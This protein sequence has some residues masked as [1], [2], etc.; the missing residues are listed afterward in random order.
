MPLYWIVMLLMTLCIGYLG[1][2]NRRSELLM[3]N[4][5]SSATAH[6]MLVY[7]NA[8]AIYAHDNPG[9]T[10]SPA[11]TQLGLPGWYVH[12]VGINGYVAGGKSY[13]FFPSPPNG[14]V[15]ALIN[16]TGS[17][18]IGYA[19]GSQ[20]VSPY[21]GQTGISLPGTVPNGSAVAFQ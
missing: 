21:G 20:L 7:R 14:L 4:A 6:N 13:T 12:Q 16:L 15:S 5:S 19:S 3:N 18:A 10:G 11:D 9:V 8:I 17:E 2:A 1:D